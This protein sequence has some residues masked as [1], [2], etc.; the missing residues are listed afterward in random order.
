MAKTIRRYKKRVG[1]EGKL[2]GKRRSSKYRSVDTY[3]N[4]VYRKNKSRIEGKILKPASETRSDREIFKSKVKEYM[5]HENPYT[6]KKYTVDEA[7]D[8]VKH[9]ELITS[10]ERRRTEVSM[11]RIKENDPENWKNIRKAIGWKQK[12]NP[13]NI[14]ESWSEGKQ[15][16]YRYK[17]P[18]TGA[19]VIIVESISPK[20]GV[21]KVEVFD[22][23]DYREQILKTSTDPASMAELAVQKALN[24]RRK[25]E[26]NRIREINYG[27]DYIRY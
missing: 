2:R 9:S 14:V 26:I 4:A 13:D 11:T 12:F 23:G 16:Y 18:Q 15:N 24:N 3:I 6:G 25:D 19:D 8:A 1:E 10:Q 21:I 5:K 17:D 27:K 22:F 7:I 20:V